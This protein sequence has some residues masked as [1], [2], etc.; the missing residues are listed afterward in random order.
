[1]LVRVFTGLILIVT[2]SWGNF[3]S[4]S[5]NTLYN[6]A[7]RP[8]FHYSP[9]CRWMN[10]PNGM[11]YHDGEYHL[12][13]QFHPEGLTWGPMHWGH[14]VSSDLVHW[15]TLPIALYPDENGTIFSGSVVIDHHNSAGFGEGAMVAFYSYH[16]QTQGIAYS[17]DRGRTWTK[18]EG[19]PV[20]DA[21]APDFRDP[22][23]LWHE[24]SQRWVA[25]ISAGQVIQFFTSENLLDWT[26]A[27][28]FS[29]GHVGVTWE[30]PDLF[31]LEINGETKWVLLVSVSR[32]APA[33]GSGIQYFIGDFDGTTFTSDYPADILWLDYGPD[34]YAGTTWSN[35]PQGRRIYIGWMS[36]WLYAAHTPTSPWRGAVTLPRELA[37]TETPDGLR[38][39]QQPVPELAALREPLGVWENIT[40][41]GMLAL[42]DIR[43][44]TLEIIAEFEPGTAE[45][46][47][48]EVQRGVEMTG[49]RVL[50]N[51]RFNQLVMSRTNDSIHPDFNPF[52]SAPYPAESNRMRLRIFVDES[53]VEVFADDG[54]I[55]L[56][57]QTFVESAADGVAVFAEGGTAHLRHLEVYALRSIWDQAAE[58]ASKYDFCP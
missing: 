46:V 12:F 55:V 22:K 20:M 57:G 41:D 23:A 51:T 4:V 26:F 5:T 29:G 45:R 36:N 47:G 53:S 39:T 35:E 25:P 52:F 14:A 40:L 56:T 31:P 27:S 11:V 15:E 30:V 13:Y 33:G 48:I 38:L 1:M 17:R 43:G 34:N 50:L 44:R 16:T 21:L 32:A 54:Q 24:T 8:Q 2:T 42:D 18:Y 9:P 6:E 3:M 19:N 58:T 10:D 37:L 7:F 49:S 28:Q